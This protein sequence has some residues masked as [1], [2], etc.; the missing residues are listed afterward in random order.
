M[1]SNWKPLSQNC[2]ELHQ[3]NKKQRSP[4]H[5]GRILGCEADEKPSRKRAREGR[6]RNQKTAGTRNAHRRICGRVRPRILL[7]ES[8]RE[9]FLRN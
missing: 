8:V 4:K 3:K 5:A 6:K 7:G 2:S 9:E 1:K